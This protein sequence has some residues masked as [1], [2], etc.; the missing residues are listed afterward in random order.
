VIKWISI[1]L[2]RRFSTVIHTVINGIMYNE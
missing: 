2:Y 1:E